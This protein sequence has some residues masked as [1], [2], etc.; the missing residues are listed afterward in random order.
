MQR[1]TW[2]WKA[3]RGLGVGIPCVLLWLSVRGLR[4]FGA[5]AAAS[6]GLLRVSFRSKHDAGLAVVRRVPENPGGRVV[7]IGDIHGCIEEFEELLAKVNFVPEMDILVLTGDLVGKGPAPLKVIDKAISLKAWLTLGNHDYSL[8]RWHAAQQISEDTLSAGSSFS[9][10]LRG[11]SRSLTAAQVHYFRSAS[12]ILEIPHHG[13]LVAHAGLVPGIP[14]PQQNAYTVMHMRNLARQHELGG[15][16]K[17]DEQE[18]WVGL[19]EVDEGEA[20]GAM[21]PG[22]ETVVFGHDARR[23]LQQHR[24]AV[25][26]DTGCVYGGELTAFVLPGSTLVSVSA[27]RAYVSKPRKG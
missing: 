5:S 16:K 3:L 6:S 22:P 10:E 19:E 1:V 25:G 23:R 17:E 4:L 26:L 14:A 8:L 9:S 7:I 20:W 27:H 15:T 24:F 21:W 18:Q 11:L 2:A 13:V 12:H